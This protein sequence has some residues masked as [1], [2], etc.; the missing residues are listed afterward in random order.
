MTFELVENGIKCLRCGL[1]YYN[2]RDVEQLYCGK[3]KLFHERNLPPKEESE[4]EL[5]GQRDE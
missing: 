2:R 5:K 3:C 1:T 4:K